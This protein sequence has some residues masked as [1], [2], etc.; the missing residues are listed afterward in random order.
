MTEVKSPTSV[1]KPTAKNEFNKDAFFKA[2]VQLQIP[3]KLLKFG[4]SGRPGLREFQISDDCK[5]IIWQSKNK[6]DAK[7][8]ITAWKEIKYGQRTEKFKRYPMPDHEQLS[9]SIIY[10]DSK[11]TGGEETLDLICKDEKE[12]QM[13]ADTLG[14]VLQQRV[15]DKFME[16]LRTYAKAQTANR[17]K[18][19]AVT[20]KEK[21]QQESNDVYAFGWGEWGQNGLTVS[22]T[23]DQTTPKLLETLL[24]QGVT[25]AAC[26]WSHTVVLLETGAVYAYGSRTGTGLAQDTFSPTPV[27]AISEKTSVTSLACGSFHCVALTSLGTVLT[28]GSN[29]YGQLGHGHNKDVKEPTPVDELT[30]SSDNE[31]FIDSVACG[32][33]FTAALT[34][35]GKV[36]TW[37][38]CHHGALGHND[39]KDA[40]VPK[41]VQDLDGF[42][43]QKIACGEGH[44]FACTDNEAY[45]WGWNFAGQLGVGHTEDQL[46]PH[47][48]DALR[49]NK[50]E[51]IA[52]GAAHTAAVVVVA[53]INSRLLYTW[54][55][56]A[57]G[58]LGQGKTKRLLAPTAVAKMSK[59]A[60]QEVSCG[61]LHTLLRSENGEIYSAG[62]GKFGQLGLTNK[63]NEDDFKLV[64]SVKGKNGRVIACGGQ[65]SVVLTARAWVE[66]SEAKNCMNC[67]GL[68]TTFNRK[69]HCRNCFGIFCGTCSSKKVAL[70]RTGSTS[71][72]RVCIPCYT[73]LTGKAA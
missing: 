47:A 54:G 61:S 11:A 53:Q 4:A 51:S 65:H 26:G 49:G 23:T 6:A 20:K 34:E 70:L 29:L 8:D 28:W 48:I 14:K 72:Q 19:M 31:M 58:Q 42:D 21:N 71:L 43:V 25:A 45:G 17:Q 67:K 7:V 41:I 10:A 44:M 22:D 27:S 56:N 46:R 24:G 73:K 35:D 69:H 52:C 66:D 40:N 16:E 33:N 13:W 50:I 68:F 2:V 39:T 57:C 37:G 60:I 5:S 64:D 38:S 30:G 3:T 15:D 55:S 1:K 36:F 12:F 18:N 62:Y 32:A 63:E 59:A 9:F